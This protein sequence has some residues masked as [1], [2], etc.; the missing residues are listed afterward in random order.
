[1]DVS[2]QRECHVPFYCE[3]DH[4]LLSTHRGE[5]WRETQVLFTVTLPRKDDNLIMCLFIHTF[6]SRFA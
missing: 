1:M 2:H 6:Q 3:L 4:V 5:R